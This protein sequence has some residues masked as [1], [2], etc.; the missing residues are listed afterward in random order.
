[1]ALLCHFN[2]G[3]RPHHHNLVI[4]KAQLEEPFLGILIFCLHLLSAFHL[5]SLLFGKPSLKRAKR[6]QQK[7]PKSK[8]SKPALKGPNRHLIEALGELFLKQC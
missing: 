7:K 3:A 1:M 4:F 6:A 5:F 8:R 2:L